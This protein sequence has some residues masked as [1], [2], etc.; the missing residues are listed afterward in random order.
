[1]LEFISV[2]L[3]SALLVLCGLAG[4]TRVV[5]EVD[6][7]QQSKSTPSEPAKVPAAP[8]ATLQ[9]TGIPKVSLEN[10][11]LHRGVVLGPDGHPLPGASIYAASTI[12]LLEISKADKV[13]VKDLGPVRAV[14]DA[15]GRFEFDA[16]DLSWVT[17]AGVRKRWETLL[18]AA[19]DGV[20]SGWIETYGDD[21]SF[22]QHWNPFPSKDVAIRTRP[23][24][25]LAGT[26]SL[27]GGTPLADARVR[28]TALFAPSE[29]DLDRHI[30]KEE[31]KE[32]G[33]FS[34]INYAESLHRP[35]LL[36]GLKTE[37]TTDNDG[38]FELPSLPEGFIASLEVAHPQ[39]VT[40]E[41]RAA[42]RRIEPVYRQS[43]D[44]REEA[45]PTLYGSDFKI[46]LQKGVILRGEVTSADWGSKTKAAGISVALANHNSP[47]GTMGKRFK[48]DSEGRFLVT[49]LARN[50]EGYELAFAGSFAAP[51]RSARQRVVSGAVARVELA[52]AV[53]YRLKL[54]DREGNPIDRTVFSVDVQ[55]T[56]GTTRRDIKTAFNDAERVALGVYEGIVP[57]GPGAVL[58]KRGKKTDRPAAVNPKA[59]FEPGRTDWTPEEERYAY[60]DA[61][62]I[63]TPG[64][65]IT[66]ALAVNA[67]PLQDQL[68]LAAAVFTRASKD[69]GVLELTAVVDSDP[70]VVFTLVDLAGKP[71]DNVRVD[72]LAGQYNGDKLPSNI[73]VFGLHPERAEPLQF[74]QD[75]REL[76]ATVS[77][78]W[79]AK[80]VRVVLQ[81][82]ATLTGRFVDRVGQPKF[83]FIIR[84]LGPGVMPD[85]FVAGRRLNITDKPGEH[86]GEF[87]QVL[88]PGLE[89]RGEFVRN[90]FDALEWKT[91]P[92]LGPAFGPVI[93]KPGETI[94]LGNIKSP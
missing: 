65:S 86:S 56:P 26:F 74:F 49:G 70:P 87:R 20:V 43:F 12:E 59:F 93:P 2:T 25:T 55:Q 22:R 68:G 33:L 29:Y 84:I 64:V 39:A 82:A 9:W 14:T 17:P 79:T 92:A 85:T 90:T 51:F 54:T 73:S 11:T 34:G 91:R 62:H 31:K 76:I 80:P 40:T 32:K 50:L 18:V 57:I 67:N 75:Q 7:T 66:D 83:D 5:A 45:T 81:S 8:K 48:T 21:R 38:R 69:Q 23:P 19:R 27:E 63:A 58:V 89:V 10:P 44:G 88:T 36:P 28:L 94:D 53:P 35:W 72:R 4:T 77:A 15:Q 78:K 71:V 52:D 37:A 46:E 30:P 24:V 61:W 3:V 1:M 16:Q 47:D 41:L 60:G 13:G 6:G 42:V